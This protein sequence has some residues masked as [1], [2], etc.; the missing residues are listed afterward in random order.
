MLKGIRLQ[1]HPTDHQKKILSQWMGCARYIWNA[2]T[3]EEK[4]QR[5]ILSKQDIYPKIDASYAHFKSKEETPWLF[6]VPSVILRNSI[7]DW[8]DTYQNFFKKQCGR[9][10][11]KKK[12]GRGSV[13]LTRELFEFVKGEDGV[14]RLFIGNKKHNI[15]YLSI[16]SHRPYRTPNSLYIRKKHNKYWVSFCYEDHTV[17]QGHLSEKEHLKDLSKKGKDYLETHTIGIDRGVARPVQSSASDTFF[18]FSQGEKKNKHMLEKQVRRFQKQLSRQKKGSNRRHRTKIRLSD[19]HASIANIRENFCHQTSRKIVDREQTKVIIFENLGTKRMTRKPKAKQDEN[20]KWLRNNARAKA[21]LN[22]SILDKSWHLLEAFT[23]YKA[24]NEGKIVFKVAPN[25]TSQECAH[26]HH[27][28]PKNRK[29]QDKFLCLSCGHTDNA[30]INAAK[31]IKQRA[32]QLILN[33]GTELSKR[34]VL[35]LSDSGRGDMLDK[36]GSKESLCSV[37]EASKKK[38]ASATGS[39]NAL[40]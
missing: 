23:K 29:K 28:H 9:P 27:I 22:K 35:S 10:K 14:T 12:D 26:C 16:K 2:K 21:G 4:E 15:G 8:R 39:P 25:H 13:Y 3:S 31:V 38:V 34:G 1:A 5:L 17:S 33:S 11:H 6:D 19:R 7:S 37:G 30:D 18:D 24:K 40:A 32:I 20:G 36:K